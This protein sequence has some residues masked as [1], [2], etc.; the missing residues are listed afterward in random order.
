MVRGAKKLPASS[1]L[2]APFKNTDDVKGFFLGESVN[3]DGAGR[4]GTDDGDALDWWAGHGWF[5][6][7]SEDIA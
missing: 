4:A 1:G 7:K 3:G 2:F 5:D 6:W